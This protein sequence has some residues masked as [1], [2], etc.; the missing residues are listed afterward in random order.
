M[1]KLFLLRVAAPILFFLLAAPAA[2]AQTTVTLQQDVNA[3][4]GTT[5]TR[6]INNGV[7]EGSRT[8]YELINESSTSLAIRFAIF[9]SEGGPVPNGATINSA[10]LSLYK[11]HGPASSFKA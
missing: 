7:Q 9:Q 2:L 11:Y 5:D 8:V 1:F 6:L 4:T 3:Y 10:T